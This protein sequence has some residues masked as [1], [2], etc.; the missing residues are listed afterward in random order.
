MNTVKVSS[1][2]QWC[3]ESIVGVCV[4]AGLRLLCKTLNYELQQLGTIVL[5]TISS[6][7]PCHMLPQKLLVTIGEDR[8]VILGQELLGEFFQS[9]H[10]RPNNPR[11]WCCVA[12]S[13]DL[14]LCYCMK[15]RLERGDCETRPAI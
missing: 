10:D 6:E 3:D 14:R 5:Q 12:Q 7:V 1:S 13:F 9:V 2:D 4:L 8:F 11:Y 15:H